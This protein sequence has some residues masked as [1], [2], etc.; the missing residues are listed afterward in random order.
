VT[1]LTSTTTYYFAAKSRD[2]RSNWSVMSNVPS[3]VAP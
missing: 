3:A 1:G 2:N